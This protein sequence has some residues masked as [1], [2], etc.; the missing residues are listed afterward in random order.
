[1]DMPNLSTLVSVVALGISVASM[2]YSRHVSLCMRHA[3]DEMAER[4]RI[5]N[6]AWVEKHI[7][8]WRQGKLKATLKRYPSGQS[9][10][11]IEPLPGWTINIEREFQAAVGLASRTT[12]TATP[13]SEDHP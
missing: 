4:R 12:V 3:A 1:M 7:D 8:R 5:G 6:D 10:H 13:T 2:L 9:L 11:V